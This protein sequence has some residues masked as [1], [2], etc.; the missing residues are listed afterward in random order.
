M[1]KNC[2]TLFRERV[3]KSLSDV[4][5]ITAVV[6]LADKRLNFISSEDW[7]Q[8]YTKGVLKVTQNMVFC[9]D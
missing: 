7:L 5:P 3:L 8:G 1:I 4:F 2:R 6:I 9:S